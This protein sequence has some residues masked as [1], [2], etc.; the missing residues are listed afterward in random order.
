M[1]LRMYPFGYKIKNGE[2]IIDKNEAEYVKEIFTLYCNGSSLKQLSELLNDKSVAYKEG[3]QP[4]NKSRISRIL[5]DK[6]YLGDDLYLPIIDADLFEKT[7]RLKNSKSVNRKPL[8]D[9]A[10]YLKEILVCGFCGSKYFRLID[11][12]K[13]EYWGCANGC[14][15]RWRP[16]DRQILN[17]I[18]TVA[19][20][21]ALNPEL[22]TQPMP[23]IG[24]KRTIE[25]MRMSN[26]ISGMNEQTATGFHTGKTLLFQ[27]AAKKFLACKEDKSVYTDYV[28]GQIKRIEK[29]GCVDIDFL[30]NALNKVKVIGKNEY[31]VEFING[32]EITNRKD[33]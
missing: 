16:N 4:W 3:G 14:R 15:L 24:Y 23:D 33:P 17:G 29:S 9:A 5:A 20:K 7:N 6:R 11:Q 22:L 32:A 8:S 26:E 31:A 12:Q 28:L 27:I 1:K 18:L 10:E 2:I 25:I 19:K 21:A 13:R 30:Q